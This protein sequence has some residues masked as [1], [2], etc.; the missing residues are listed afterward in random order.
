VTVVVVAQL[1]LY[2]AAE[3]RYRLTSAEPVVP[4]PKAQLRAGP[5]TVEVETSQPRRQV[6]AVGQV[7]EAVTVGV[8]G[9][10]GLGPGIVVVVNRMQSGSRQAVVRAGSMGQWRIAGTVMV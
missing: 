9:Q 8:V 6:A 7:P 1:L 5:V 4:G 2:G 10:A 3:R